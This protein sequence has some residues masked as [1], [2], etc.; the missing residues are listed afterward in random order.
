MDKNKNIFNTDDNIISKDEHQ[1]KIL[2]T[3]IQIFCFQ[4]ELKQKIK[5]PFQVNNVNSY[6]VNI[7]NKNTIKF[8][9]NIIIL[10]NYVLT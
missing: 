10:K 6:S 3:L 9:K 8:L 5:L 7:I 2:K 1:N 4:E